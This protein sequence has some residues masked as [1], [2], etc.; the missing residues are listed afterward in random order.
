MHQGRREPASDDRLYIKLLGETH[1]E[2]LARPGPEQPGIRTRKSIII[3]HVKA[4]LLTP[5]LLV[6]LQWWE[7]T[8]KVFEIPA[9]ATRDWGLRVKIKL[10][11]FPPRTPKGFACESKLASA[12]NIE[13]GWR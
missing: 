6:L 5:L 3:I 10:S 13:S 8:L 11:R 4:G 9:E 12:F 1:S 7:G 2:D